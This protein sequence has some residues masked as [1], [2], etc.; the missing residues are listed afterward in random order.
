MALPKGINDS[1]QIDI[2]AAFLYGRLT[3]YIYIELPIVHDKRQYDKQLVWRTKASIYRL[4]Q[5]PSM[6]NIGLLVYVP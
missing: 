5:S 6:W 3:D 4:E 1:S 2:S